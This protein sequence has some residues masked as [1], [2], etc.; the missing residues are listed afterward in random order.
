V[1]SL[2]SRQLAHATDQAGVC[3]AS[4]R[5]VAQTF[6]VLSV[7]IWLV[8]EATGRLVVG[9]STASQ[10]A[11]TVRQISPSAS[12]AV[13]A[14]L[15]SRARP[16]DLEEEAEPWM[17]EFRG[18]NPATFETGGHR[19]CVP[20]RSGERSLGALVLADRVGGHGYTLEEL[21]LLT[22]IGDQVTSVLLNLRLADE[23]A[24]GRELEAFRLMSTFFIHDLKNAAASLNLT[25]KNLPKHFDDPAFRGD[26]LRAVGNTAKRIDDMIAR[27]S[28][29][30]ERPGASLQETDL[31]QIVSDALGRVDPIPRIEVTQEL[32]TVPSL[33][34]D[35]EQIQSVITNLVLNAQEALGSEGRVLVRTEHRE[36]QVILSVS[37]NGCGMTPAFMNDSLFRPFQSTKKKGLGI[38]LFQ[39]RTIVQAHGG[40]VQVESEPG[41]GTT[42]QVSFPVR[43]ER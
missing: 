34:V 32:Q 12:T 18:L 3:E 4:A 24:R 16:F 35:K 2:F 17:E 20:L 13:Q 28:A 23:V 36:G 37:D 30:R 5:S 33:R 22:C 6:D 43:G 9:A 1:W 42:F 25:L 7:S 14:G 41:K 15:L 8:D 40:R 31:N 39:S 38:G 21:E 10:R 27:L 11:D 26:A 29:L 19:W